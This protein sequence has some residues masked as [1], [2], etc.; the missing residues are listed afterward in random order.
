MAAGLTTQKEG[1]REGMKELCSVFQALSTEVLVFG[2]LGLEHI[3]RELGVKPNVIPTLKGFE[4]FL[5]FKKCL[6][7]QLQQV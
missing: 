3:F 6:A 4:L 7:L 1:K 5:V 2:I